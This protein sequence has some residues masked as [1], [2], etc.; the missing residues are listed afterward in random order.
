ML[1]RT[2]RQRDA[3]QTEMERHGEEAAAII[4]KAAE[5][6]RDRSDDENSQVAEH[7]KAIQTLRKNVD[8]Y[9]RE[10]AVEKDVLG[11]ARK[12]GAEDGEAIAK[13]TAPESL[14]E[15]LVNT[16]EYKSLKSKSFAGRFRFGVGDPEE[17]P[18]DGK[19]LLTIGSSL[20]DTANVG[21]PIAPDRQAGVLGV[22]TQQ[23]TVADLINQSPTSSGVISIVQQTTNTS[24][25]D[26]IAE[27][28]SKQ[29]ATYAFDTDSVEVDT[30]AHLL[31]VT[32]QFLEDAPALVNFVNGLLTLGVR[33]R[34]EKY[35][36][37]ALIAAVSGANEDVISDAQAANDADHIYAGMTQIRLAFQEPTGIVIN[38]SNWEALRLLKDQNDN[39]IAGSPFSNTGSNPGEFL[40]GKPVV[41]TQSIPEGLAVVLTR[42]AAT[43]YR[44]SGLMVETSNSHSDFFEKN[45]TMIRAEERIAVGVWR[46]DGIATVDLLES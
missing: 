45:K 46:P 40:F 20:S 15:L 5:E 31:P 6:N 11:V 28:N 23:P 13:E 33:Q 38:P 37:D 8:E 36:L 41:V 2:E 18:V 30:I 26:V 4:D 1:S 21:G 35:V 24:A 27:T 44:R 17:A 9:E 7:Q 16:P 12:I 39:Y 43:L 14:G 34:E 3:A 42:S 32:N 29:E 22:L 25:A 10:I 19:T